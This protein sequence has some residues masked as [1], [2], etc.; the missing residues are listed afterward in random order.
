LGRR[1]QYARVYQR[2]GGVNKCSATTLSSLVTSV[3]F[4]CRNMLRHTLFAFWLWLELLKTSCNGDTAIGYQ[5]RLLA[6][7]ILALEVGVDHLGRALSQ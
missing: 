2:A 5:L 1:N 3:P 6:L 4:W 7:L